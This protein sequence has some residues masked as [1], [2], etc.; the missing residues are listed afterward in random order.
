[1]KAR[2]MDL[3]GTVLSGS[4]TEFGKYIV[5]QTEKW[6]KVIEFADIKPE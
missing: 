2:I 6:A 1:M 5:D 4:A 3:G